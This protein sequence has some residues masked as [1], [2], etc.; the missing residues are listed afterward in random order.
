ME[1]RSHTLPIY[2]FPQHIPASQS[3]HDLR[4]AQRHKHTQFCTELRDF[5]SSLMNPNHNFPDNFLL[6]HG[7]KII[8]L[9]KSTISLHHILARLPLEHGE[10]ARSKM[11]TTYIAL[12]NLKTDMHLQDFPRSTDREA[13]KQARLL[14]TYIAFANP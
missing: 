4:E 8:H 1:R 9:A 11:L 12:P 6:M 14:T 7:K 5:F 2:N 10:G 3:F 13:K